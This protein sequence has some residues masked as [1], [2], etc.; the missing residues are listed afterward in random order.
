MRL[1][2]AFAAAL[3]LTGTVR[4][5]SAE[6][7]E[8][9]TGVIRLFQER[10][11]VAFAEQH[12]SQAQHA[13]LRRLVADPRFAAVA[14]DVVVEFGN[15]RFQRVVDRWTSGGRVAFTD[16]RRAWAETTQRSTWT[17][18]PVYEQ[19]FRA[20][21][22]ANLRRPPADRI[23]I[24]LGD[25]PIDVRKVRASD[26]QRWIDRRNTHYAGVVERQVLTKGRRALLIAGA[27]HLLRGPHPNETA[28]I[29]RRRPGSIAVVLPHIGFVGDEA[30]ERELRLARLIT[31]ALLP[32]AGTW[33]ADV[34]AAAV[35]GLHGDWGRGP[36][37]G[38]ADALLYLG[39]E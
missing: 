24:V 31:P 20:V 14:D 13:F 6:P 35:P 23:R 27:F 12:H 34:P 15:A 1:A 21:R 32:T 37:S 8:G 33:L 9:V 10:P 30:E 26:W 5:G 22:A 28:M 17:L 4:G 39:P 3:T 11:L 25:P 38:R 18:T 7:E 2:L 16:V 29:E 19:F 36:L